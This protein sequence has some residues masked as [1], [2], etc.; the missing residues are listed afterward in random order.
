MQFMQGDECTLEDPMYIIADSTTIDVETLCQDPP[1]SGQPAG[2]VDCDLDGNGENDITLL[3]GGNRSWL[4]LDGGGGGGA[5]LKDWITGGYIDDIYPHT[6]V[7]AQSGVNGSV[8]DTVH[9]EILNKDVIMPVFDQFCPDGNPLY[10][11][12]GL[13]HPNAES[14]EDDVI[15][16]NEPHDYFH[17]ISFA[18]W[19]TTCIEAGSHKNCPGRNKLDDILAA[20]GWSNGNIQSLMTMEGCFKEGFVPGVKG[21]GG[22]IP[23]AGLWTIYLTK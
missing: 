17:L 16:G 18:Y 22:G 5:E 7:A 15:V 12:P 23:Y 6:W 21:G 20:A 4:D 19:R 8:Y 1:N 11:C 3:S 9:D 14:D 13:V 10:N 2:A